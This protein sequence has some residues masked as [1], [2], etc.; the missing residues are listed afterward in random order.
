[1]R[2]R[3]ENTPRTRCVYRS[4]AACMFCGLLFALFALFFLPDKDFSETEKRSLAQF[5]ELRIETLA[6][7]KA[8]AALETYVQDQMPLRNFWVGGRVSHP[9][10]HPGESAQ[11]QHQ[12]AHAD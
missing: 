4:V 10:A 6:N 8:E 9:H 3:T 7:G 5:P 1:M 2:N 11:S 12:P